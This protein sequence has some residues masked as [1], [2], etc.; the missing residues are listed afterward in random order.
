MSNKAQTS[1]PYS[2]GQDPASIEANRAYQDALKKLTESLDQRKNRFF[3][4]TLLAAAQGFMQPGTS[5]FFDS[6]GNVAGNIAK[7]QEAQIAE[8]QAIAQQRLELAGRGVELQRQKGKD[9]MI[10]GILNRKKGPPAPEAEGDKPTQSGALPSSAQPG[11]AGSAA[12]Q[13]GLSQAEPKRPEVPGEPKYGIRFA[14]AEED[15]VSEEQYI[16]LAISGGMDPAEAVKNWES[17]KNSRKQVKDTGVYDISKGMYYPA[18]YDTVETQIYGYPG[19]YK[20]SKTDAFRLDNFRRAN[21]EEGYKAYARSIAV[22]FGKSPNAAPTG[23]AVADTAPGAAPSAAVPAAVPA[24]ATGQ[25]AA[26]AG[27]PKQPVGPAAAAAG[28]PAAQSGAARP[29][30]AAQPAAAQPAAAATGTAPVAQPAA[31]RPAATGRLSQEE[32]AAQ[33]ARE[34]EIAKADVQAEI[35]KRK[36]FVQRADEAPDTITTATM[37][38][39]FAKDPDAGKMTGILSNS[40]VSSQIAT[41]LQEGIGTNDLR[42]AIPGLETAMRNAGL[43]PAQQAKFRVFLQTVEQMRLQM[44]KYAKGAV[45]DFEQRLFRAASV[46]TE[47]T[48][49]AVRMKADLLT[50]RAEFDRQAY[51]EWKKSK[52]TADEFKESD[53][54]LRMRVAY[55][56]QLSAIALGAKMFQSGAARPNAAAPAAVQPSPGFVQDKKTGVI[57]RKKEGE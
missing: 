41:L 32:L 15:P 1:A 33:V 14:E 52:L 16:A 35:E 51:K 4:P 54:Y 11:S 6:L 31:A 50:R 38:R 30:A 23:G 29:A 36:T 21:D 5:N 22:P 18:G 55:D 49:D 25:A 2:P 28:M 7:S 37:L 10:Q 48:A 56:K 13:G 9:A 19:T 44:S 39:D 3:E 47:D 20:I 43:N 57:R 26:S 34:Q 24:A 17:I 45:S 12:P 27:L 8:D 53:D 40:K 46:S 42:V